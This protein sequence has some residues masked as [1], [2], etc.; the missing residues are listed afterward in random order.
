[1]YDLQTKRHSLSHVMSQ[2]VM[3]LF[4]DIKIL[5]WVGPAID[6]GFYQDFDFWDFTLT[7]DHLKDIEKKMKQLLKQNQL[8]EMTTR[9]IDDEISRFKSEGDFYKLELAEDL[10]K[11]GETMLSFCINKMQDGR[12]SYEDMCKGP[13]VEK[14]SQLDENSFKIEKIA[15]AY[16]RG[17]A[18]NKQLTRI[19]GVAFENR[20]E[21][22]TY[23]KQI[24]EAKRRD[25]RILGKAL[26][27]FT[28]SDLVGSGLPLMQ[29]KGMVMRKLIED[30][31]WDLHKKKG[32]QRVWT[33]HLAKEELYQTSGHA[34]K[35]L[36]D[37]FSVFGGTSKEKF[38]LKPMNCPHHMQL[39]AD[40]QFSYRDMPIRYFEPATVYRDE[41]TG[42][43]S[44]L[45]RVRSITQ[46]DGHLFCR[47]SQ[48]KEEVGTIVEII[49]EFYKT[50]WLLE[51]Y[52]VSL[53]IRDPQT[54]D[55][56]IGGN[57]VWELAEKSLEEA[58][59]ASGLNYKPMPWEAAFYGP[60][61]DFMF[62]DAIGR[63]WQLATIQCDFNQPNRFELSFTNEQWE[64]ERPV[65][66]HR[67][68][69]GSLE[70]FMG[71]MIEHFAG[72]FP[73]WLAPE[74][75]IVVPVSEAFIDYAYEVK[76]AL[77]IHDIRVSV[78]SSSDSLNKKVRNAEKAHINYI[79][80]VWEEEM[81]WWS[82]A[83]RNYKTKEQ[84]V[85]KIQEFNDLVKQEIE[86]KGL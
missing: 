83:V 52:W 9:P 80:V 18:K 39:F 77:E 86:E 57:D 10:K 3:S 5:R 63:E 22:D 67:A 61:L 13:H 55:K 1:M 76:K 36:E 45:T 59:Q 43:L 8:F 23:L 19:Y 81:K 53:S 75:V 54:P 26:K 72:T 64:A 25:H 69:S 49:K 16:W 56:Y 42:Q 65:V 12:I 20:E 17:D 21:L 30:Y 68:I 38:F 62:K 35:Y 51:G 73:L 66:I 4:P 46:D 85:L 29:P 84:S 60:K 37:M 15:G 40:N 41:K 2:A 74:Q 33:P 48:I 71:I 78:D 31:L 70:R 50:F 14:M 79:L 44:G 32:Y 58:A 34:G 11:D 7:E 27:I 47:V 82:V 28:V 24:E 6:T